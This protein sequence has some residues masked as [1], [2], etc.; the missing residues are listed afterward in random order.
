MVA[1]P[2]RPVT[3]EAIAQAV[4]TVDSRVTAAGLAAKA[5]SVEDEA[6][7]RFEVPGL[8]PDD[9][10]AQGIRELVRAPGVLEFVAVPPELS[11]QVVDGGPLPKAMATIEPLF[12]GTGVAGGR[13]SEDST[14][15]QIAVDLELTESGARLF[16]EHAAEHVGERMAIVLD[17][18]VQSAP[19]LN[20][21]RFD[22][23]VQIS[24]DFSPAQADLLVAVLEA[25][26]LPI[27]L[28][29]TEW[30]ACVIDG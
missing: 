9:G 12:D 20:A 22:G 24:G 23:L 16:D 28:R 29:E 7:L 8:A 3:P 30:G 1:S 14:T 15:G 2:D 18:I 26:P 4:S 27:E 6:L 5:L 21:A 17:G 11:D 13:V 19:T 25:D 10:V